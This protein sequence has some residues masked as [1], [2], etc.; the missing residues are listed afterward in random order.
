MRALFVL[1][2]TLALASP[3]QAMIAISM[4]REPLRMAAHEA[5]GCEGAMPGEYSMTVTLGEGAPRAALRRDP[6]VTAEARACIE[7]AFASGRYPDAHHGTIRLN[8]PM[9]ITAAE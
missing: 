9:R 8:Y 3:A 4:F 6:G 5:A 7:H 1:L 2:C